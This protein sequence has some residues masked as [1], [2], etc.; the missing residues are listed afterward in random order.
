MYIKLMYTLALCIANDRHFLFSCIYAYIN[1]ILKINYIAS[2]QRQTND[3]R[4]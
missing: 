1:E 2:T 4:S 3:S